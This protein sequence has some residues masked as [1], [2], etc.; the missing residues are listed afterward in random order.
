MDL[1]NNACQEKITPVKTFF[2]LKR[3][4]FFAGPFYAGPNNAKRPKLTPIRAGVIR[5]NK[6]A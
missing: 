6:V 5:A 3:G 4:P 2:L 1:K